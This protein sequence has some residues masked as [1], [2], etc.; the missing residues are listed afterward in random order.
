MADNFGLFTIDGTN[1][2]GYKSTDVNIKNTD[3]IKV[4]EFE[5]NNFNNLSLLQDITVD[6]D[7]VYY[8]SLE[9]SSSLNEYT[10]VYKLDITAVENDI[11]YNYIEIVNI[12]GHDDII[13]TESTKTSDIEDATILVYSDFIH[14][15][16]TIPYTK[17]ILQS[18]IKDEYGNNLS[19][20][21][22]DIK[23]LHTNIVYDWNISNINSDRDENINNQYNICEIIIHK[24]TPSGYIINNNMYQSLKLNYI[25]FDTDK[26]WKEISQFY[27][28]INFYIDDT[29]VNEIT[30][31]YNILHAEKNSVSFNGYGTITSITNVNTKSTNISNFS[32]DA[33]YKDQFQQPNITFTN[34]GLIC[35]TIADNIFYIES[36]AQSVDFTN[37]YKNA[38]ILIKNFSMDKYNDNVINKYNV[39]ISMETTNHSFEWNV[40]CVI[41][42]IV[43]P[44][45]GEY[46]FNVENIDDSNDVI[47][48]PNNA[49]R[50]I[51]IKDISTGEVLYGGSYVYRLSL[52]AGLYA[53]EIINNK[54][55]FLLTV[56]PTNNV[57]L[58]EKIKYFFIP[59]DKISYTNDVA[60][61]KIFQ[62]DEFS[63]N[64]NYII[65]DS[66][67]LDIKLYENSIIKICS[68]P[69]IVYEDKYSNI[70]SIFAN[71]TSSNPIEPV[72]VYYKIDSTNSSSGQ[73]VKYNVIGNISIEVEK[74][75]DNE[76][77]TINAYSKCDNNENSVI[78][79]F[80][81]KPVKKIN[82]DITTTVDRELNLIHLYSNNNIKNISFMN[83]YGNCSIGNGYDSY[84]NE[85]E[86]NSYIEQQDSVEVLPIDSTEIQLYTQ[87]MYY[88][89]IKLQ[90]TDNTSLA[91]SDRILIDLEN[92]YINKQYY[93][94][95]YSYR[96]YPYYMIGVKNMHYSYKIE[97]NDEQIDNRHKTITSPLLDYLYPSITGHK[98]YNNK[99]FY[100]HQQTTIIFKNNLYYNVINIPVQFISDFDCPKYNELE[101]APTPDV[102]DLPISR[103]SVGHHTG[104]YGF[105]KNNKTMPIGDAI[106]KCG[107][108]IYNYEYHTD[109]KE[110]DIK[111]GYSSFT[112]VYSVTLFGTIKIQSDYSSVSNLMLLDVITYMLN[113]KNIKTFNF[114]G[115]DYDNYNNLEEFGCIYIT[116]DNK[117]NSYFWWP[118]LEQIFDDHSYRNWNNIE[119]IYAVDPINGIILASEKMPIASG[120]KNK[121][122]VFMSDTAVSNYNQV[123]NN[124]TSDETKEI[125]SSAYNTIL[126]ISDKY[127]ILAANVRQDAWGFFNQAIRNYEK[128]TAL[129]IGMDGT[130]YGYDTTV[131][132]SAYSPI[133]Q[134]LPADGD[135][136]L[137]DTEYIKEILETCTS[138]FILQGATVF[139]TTNGCRIFGKIGYSLSD[140]VKDVYKDKN[141]TCVELNDFELYN[142]YVNQSSYPFVF[143]HKHGGYIINNGYKQFNFNTTL[144]VEPRN[145]YRANDDMSWK[146]IYMYDNYRPKWGISPVRHV[147]KQGQSKAY[148]KIYRT[149]T[150]SIDYHV[151]YGTSSIV[152]Y[153]IS[154]TYSLT[155]AMYQKNTES[156]IYIISYTF[157]VTYEGNNIYGEGN[158]DTQKNIIDVAG[159]KTHAI[160]LDMDST[161]FGT[162]SN[163]HGQIDVNNLPSGNI[164]SI[165]ACD[166]ITFALDYDGTMHYTGLLVDVSVDYSNILKQRDI[167]KIYTLG[168]DLYGL[169]KEGRFV[170]KCGE[171]TFSNSSVQQNYRNICSIS[172]RTAP[173]INHN[174]DYRKFYYTYGDATTQYIS[175]YDNDN[176]CNISMLGDVS[177]FENY[178]NDIEIIYQDGTIINMNNIY[179]YSGNNNHMVFLSAGLVTAIGDDTYNQCSGTS[180]QQGIKR[181]AC[182]LEHTVGLTDTNTLVA[183]GNNNYGQCDVDLTSNPMY[184]NVKNIQCTNYNTIIL[185][186]DNSIDI[187]GSNNYGLTDQTTIDLFVD[188]VKISVGNNHI[189]G[190]KKSGDIVFAGDNSFSQIDQNLFIGA[191]D[192]YASDDYTITNKYDGKFYTSSNSPV[193]G[194]DL[195]EDFLNNIACGTNYIIGTK[196]NL[197]KL[198]SSI[199]YQSHIT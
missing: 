199:F 6:I 85:Y 72:D 148:P 10:S 104:V 125:I 18:V 146:Q 1:Y 107:I 193:N 157:D 43:I 8:I 156:G 13:L 45:D 61:L 53:I 131:V 108:D 166:N 90:V 55:K 183:V 26:Q 195:N 158:V 57:Y 62:R 27:P 97:T 88:N 140:N 126:S 83:G 189:I 15:D 159:A 198:K 170:F 197:Y 127:D 69:T 119:K 42:R 188:I 92:I 101:D 122:K 82:L 21:L 25:L 111:D 168:N 151:Y 169:T 49:T 116:S 81:F 20:I 165:K 60:Y 196:Q 33:D 194:S 102:Y 135:K 186:S 16:S 120:Y 164:R 17:N 118:D 98:F 150:S 86:Q 22:Y 184:I 30:R 87:N 185:L 78:N 63:N 153:N 132:D 93:N 77:Y 105:N 38:N 106:Y 50:Q 149:N 174:E 109:I 47:F 75:I 76:I 163:V 172:G 7:Y 5:N 58:Y 152:N 11:N 147:N 136:T 167:D 133:N 162:G 110:I 32:I 28:P 161:I 99:H 65:G 73:L 94:S 123:Y 134:I 44:F 34:N 68:T 24:Q 51:Y 139:N 176:I 114:I 115:L 154:N 113:L 89:N 41:S 31:V 112:L 4:Y 142:Y 137:T 144:R 67:I 29:S 190:I 177:I 124:S 37:G 180:T 52:K 160:G 23:S 2:I 182:G 175:T 56:T 79:I 39:P 187:I 3:N 103:V 173:I 48:P 19:N 138:A 64:K 96:Q 84:P 14:T 171:T 71:G 181:T 46:N 36:N 100:S 130:L 191:F 9:F 95:K 178:N 129:A 145:D 192:V 74:F 155:T 70:I 91:V 117:I 59:Y 80:K 54:S 128:K 12:F 179:N 141:Y 143:L 35:E 40:N 121:C 66:D